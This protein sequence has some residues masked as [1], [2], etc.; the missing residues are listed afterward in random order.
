VKFITGEQQGFSAF[1]M[2]VYV[3][4]GKGSWCWAGMSST[5]ASFPSPVWEYVSKGVVCVC[6]CLSVCTYTHLCSMYVI[7]ER[8]ARCS[9]LRV[10]ERRVMAL[11]SVLHVAWWGEKDA[12]L[13]RACHMSESHWHDLL[14]PSTGFSLSKVSL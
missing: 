5:C 11:S 3:T 9:P 10:G 7:G 6:V 2:G 14:L 1:V 8:P 4:R 13:Y 12:S